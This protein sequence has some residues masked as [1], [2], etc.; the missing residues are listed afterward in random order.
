M[1]KDAAWCLPL[2][3]K[4]ARGT[5]WCCALPHWSMVFRY[6]STKTGSYT[7]Q[8]E[9]LPL[10][11][12]DILCAPNRVHS[13]PF[14]LKL[15]IFPNFFNS[16]PSLQRHN[17]WAWRFSWWPS[18]T[19]PLWS[20]WCWWPAPVPIKQITTCQSPSRQQTPSL[21][22]V[23]TTLD[24]LAQALCHYQHL[25]PLQKNHHS[26]IAGQWFF[27][28]LHEVKFIIWSS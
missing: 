13:V 24:M 25:K 22:G 12:M 15:F 28:Q 5:E 14:L 3:S 11:I 26:Q 23:L 27:L 9:K 6:T 7:L 1:P 21:F 2:G 16:S 19:T 20:P 17:T 10:L 4:I 8:L 18:S